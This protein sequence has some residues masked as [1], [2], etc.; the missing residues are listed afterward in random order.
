MTK[1]TDDQISHA[2]KIEYA[3]NKFQPFIDADSKS[4][5][6]QSALIAVGAGK[7]WQVF[8]ELLFALKP[9][10]LSG[11]VIAVLRNRIKLSYAKRL[12]SEKLENAE[13]LKRVDNMTKDRLAIISNCHKLAA[14]GKKG[15]VIVH[16]Q[17]FAVVEKLIKAHKQGGIK[18]FKTVISEAVP[19]E[20]KAAPRTPTGASGQTAQ[21]QKGLKSV[22]SESKAG[23]PVMAIDCKAALLRL[24]ENTLAL[25]LSSDFLKPGTDAKILK[26]IE[27]LEA[28]TVSELEVELQKVA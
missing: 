1:I 6:D 2:A 5:F 8:S 13:L 10:I 14:G 16:G 24:M 12:E 9:G 17:G 3:V 20:L 22:K 23:G 25:A 28:A 11:E 7:E 4:S 18:A 15:D 27:Q 26:L 19:A 21:V